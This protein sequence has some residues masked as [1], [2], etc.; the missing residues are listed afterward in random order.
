M[1]GV[2]V[3][4]LWFLSHTDVPIIVIITYRSGLHLLKPELP[5]GDVAGKD[6]STETFLAHQLS[7]G[8]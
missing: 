8:F 2:L 5:G 4:R 1:T 6:P 3:V 7:S